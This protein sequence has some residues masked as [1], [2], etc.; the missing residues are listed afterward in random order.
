MIELD[1]P[2]ERK[3]FTPHLTLARTRRDGPMS[4]TLVQAAQRFRNTVF[5]DFTA[6]RFHLYESRLDSSGATYRKLADYR[7]V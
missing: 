4:Q 1:F 3:T 5:G 6:D 7:L 2:P